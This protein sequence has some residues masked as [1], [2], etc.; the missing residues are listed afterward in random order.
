M[1]SRYSA[2]HLKLIDYIELTTDPQA[3]SEIDRV[4]NKQWAEKAHFKKLEV[5][6]SKED[7]NKGVVEF[8]AYFSIE[9]VPE[10]Q[11]HHEVSTFRKQ[12]GRWYFRAG[13]IIEAPKK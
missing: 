11:T 8:K 10:E 6:S 5:L 12:K 4:S 1:R 13:R 7:G 3:L 9:G 2:Y